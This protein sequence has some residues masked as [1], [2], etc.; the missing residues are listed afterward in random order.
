MA[1]AGICKKPNEAML[2][3]IILQTYRTAKKV[4]SEQPKI[5]VLSYSSFGSGGNDD[6][7][8]LIRNTISKVHEKHPEI[9]IDGEMQLDT[10]VNETIGAKKSN[11]TSLVAGHANV[12]ICPDLNS[13]NILY[14]GLEQL[15]GWTAAGPILQGFDYIISDL[16][17]GS[18]VE[19]IELIFDIIKRLSA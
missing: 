5:A 1:D 16:S 17:R 8:E 9:L 13:G 2:Y 11:N 6:T 10:A 3:A 12:L 7:I 19:D 14:K 15:G 4:L 18:S